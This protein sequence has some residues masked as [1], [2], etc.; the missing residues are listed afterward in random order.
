LT[1]RS[2]A[3]QEHEIGV[4]LDTGFMGSLTLPRALIAS[5]GLRWRA[6]GMVTLANGIEDYCDI[7]A[8]TIIWDGTPR[9]IL[10]EA[11]ETDPLLG[12]A[13]LYGLEIRIRAVEGGSVAIEALS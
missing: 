1:V 13:L 4:V 8:A 5:L 11:A 7:Y 9:D 10:V 6:R 12:M 3:G 2:A